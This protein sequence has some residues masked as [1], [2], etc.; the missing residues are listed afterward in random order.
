MKLGE[1]HADGTVQ[2]TGLH[3]WVVVL[4][5]VAGT[6]ELDRALAKLG[7]DA[8]LSRAGGTRAA[9]RLRAR[10]SVPGVGY[11]AASNAATV[12][13]VVRLFMRISKPRSTASTFARA[14]GSF[15]VTAAT[16]LSRE[17]SSPNS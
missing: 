11:P 9:R 16:N 6:V 4:K 15:E 5:V 3:R 8:S 10:G 1:E 7:G 2:E 14:A 13:S 17:K 12:S